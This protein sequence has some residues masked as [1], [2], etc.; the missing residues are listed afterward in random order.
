MD[1]SERIAETFLQGLSL[2]TVAYEPDGNIPPDF[3]V[4]GTIAVEVRR[5]NENVGSEGLEQVDIPLWHNMQRLVAEM[6]PPLDGQTWGILYRFSRPI[7]PWSVLRP[8][9]AAALEEFVLAPPPGRRLITVTPSFN[10]TIFRYPVLK[11]TMY[12]CSGSVDQQSGGSL[13]PLLEKNIAHCI[14]EKSIKIAPFKTRYS[15]WWLVLIDRIGF[16]LDDFDRGLF[17][18]QVTLS[19]SWDRVVILAPQDPLRPFDV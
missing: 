1:D 9:I 10:M 6:G 7:E 17:R 16:G 14:A 18:D 8:Q 5:L 19:H 2:G 3:V 13:I 4:G 11:P 15:T 12:L